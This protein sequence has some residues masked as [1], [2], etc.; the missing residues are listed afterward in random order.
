MPVVAVGVLLLAEKAPP[1]PV[2]ELLAMVGA[3]APVD[4]TAMLRTQ[5]SWFCTRTLIQPPCEPICSARVPGVSF[6][7]TGP[8]SCG[9]ARNSLDGR[10]LYVNPG[11]CQIV[12]YT[13]EELEQMTWQ[14][15]THPED[16]DAD[17]Q[18]ASRVVAGDATSY[19]MEKRYIRK[20]GGIVW[21]SLHGSIVKDDDEIAEVK[22]RLQARGIELIPPFA[23][24]F[25]DP[26]GNRVQVVDLS[27][28]SPWWATA[29]EHAPAEA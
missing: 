21:V 27:V 29:L 3:G 12:G 13:A 22:R 17:V 5:P 18:Y 19:T 23:C 24:D 28:S 2:I 25:R 7:M 16:V 26:W 15:I 4:L 6:V 14:Q 1:R 20:D 10:F 9:V 8:S 11:F